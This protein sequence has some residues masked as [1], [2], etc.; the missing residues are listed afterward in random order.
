M[1]MS[2]VPELRALCLKQTS[3]GWS[4]FIDYRF[5]LQ[6]GGAARAAPT[7]DRSPRHTLWEVYQARDV[8][9]GRTAITFASSVPK[10]PPK[11]RHEGAYCW[12]C[13]EKEDGRIPGADAGTEEEF[14]NLLRAARVILD[15]G[16]T[17]E[18]KIVPTLVF[19]ANSDK[20]LSLKGARESVV[21]DGNHSTIS[22][23]SYL[24][25]AGAF[26]NFAVLS[27]VRRGVPILHEAPAAMT[28]LKDDR[29]NIEEIAIDVFKRSVRRDAIASLY[30][31]HLK[32]EGVSY[33]PNR[34]E[35]AYKFPQRLSRVVSQNVGSARNQI[36]GL[37]GCPHTP[38][39]RRAAPLS[40]ATSRSGSVRHLT[41]LS[42]QR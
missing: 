33:D 28:V 21:A 20:V 6:R 32:K 1:G 10:Y 11:V 27:E 15:I 41:W 14:A 8:P 4:N 24:W 16:I 37:C 3:Q 38:Y 25:F 42:K 31:G 13:Q 17:D 22:E 29:G 18:D 34:G 39:D 2:D 35:L 19:A 7:K 12:R 5:R 30:A 26:D 40:R 23:E 36:C 9:E